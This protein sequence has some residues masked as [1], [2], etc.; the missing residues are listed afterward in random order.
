MVRV[1]LKETDV[2]ICEADLDDFAGLNR[3][4]EDAGFVLYDLTQITRIAD[5]SLGWFYPVYLN[6]RLDSIRQRPFWDASRDELVIEKQ[7]QRRQSILAKNAELLE[8][9]RAARK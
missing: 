4:L 3:I 7:N 6:R 9:I 8:L 1:K 5:Q 2:V